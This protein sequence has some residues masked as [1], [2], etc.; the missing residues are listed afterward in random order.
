M[1]SSF[2]Y[3]VL[4]INPRIQLRRLI[5]VALM[6]VVLRSVYQQEAYFNALFIVLGWEVNVAVYMLCSINMVLVI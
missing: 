6:G 2:H 4:K 1:P 3:E 5:N